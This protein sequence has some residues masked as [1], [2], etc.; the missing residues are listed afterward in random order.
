MTDT[1]PPPRA[2]FVIIH[3]ADKHFSRIKLFYILLV[4]YSGDFRRSQGWPHS[5]VEALRGP[6][7]HALCRLPIRRLHPRGAGSGS[8][9][10]LVGP[11]P[12]TSLAAY[13]PVISSE[14]PMNGQRVRGRQG[15]LF[16]P[17][18]G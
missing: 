5:H 14:A 10:D 7:F 11:A 13:R 9:I 16:A 8:E 4:K 17:F 15:P 18:S 1:S 6:A 12:H 2:L 3:Q